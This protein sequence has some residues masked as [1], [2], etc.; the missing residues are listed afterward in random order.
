MPDTNRTG[1]DAY[2]HGLIQFAQAVVLGSARVLASPGD[3]RYSCSQ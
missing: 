2:M 1:I 3:E